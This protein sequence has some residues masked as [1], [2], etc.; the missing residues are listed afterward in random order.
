MRRATP[1]IFILSL[2]CCGTEPPGIPSPTGLATGDAQPSDQRTTGIEIPPGNETC[3]FGGTQIIT[4]RDRDANYTYNEAIDVIVSIEYQCRDGHPSGGD[5]S[6]GDQ[7][8]TPPGG[9]VAP[10]AFAGGALTGPNSAVSIALSAQDSDGSVTAYTLTKLPSNGSVNITNNTAIYTPNPG[11]TGKDSFT[12]TAKDDRGKSSSEAAINVLVGGKAL[13]VADFNSQHPRDL[14]MKAIMEELGLTVTVV[15]DDDTLLDYGLDRIPT[16]VDLAFISETVQSGSIGTKLNGLL[17]PTLIWDGL[18]CRSMQ[19]TDPGEVLRAQDQTDISIRNEGHP[20]LGGFKG[21][22]PV[23]TV[24][25]LLGYFTAVRDAVVLA[26][27][28]GDATKPTAFLVD[29][30][31]RDWNGGSIPGRRICMPWFTYNS[32][33]GTLTAQG[34]ALFRAFSHYAVAP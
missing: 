6:T 30:G 11:Y 7:A 27:L 19:L 10:V 13:F 22:L 2:M 8:T 16:N 32:S 29:A 24:P 1:L 3:P 15:D 21:T 9:N 23:S 18:V 25:A 12:F 28:A 31:K 26:S 34:K 5:A 4:Y 20:A 33:D 17:I 14:V